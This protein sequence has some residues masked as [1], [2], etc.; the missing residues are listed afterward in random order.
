MFYHMVERVQSALDVTYAA[1][2]DPTRRAIL[3]RLRRGGAASVTQ[4]ARQFPVSLNAVSKHI[5]VLEGAGLVHRE[6]RGREHVL[7]LDAAP[8]AEAGSWIAEY[9]TF[10]HARADALAKHVEDRATQQSPARQGL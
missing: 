5:R 3:D 2:S 7:S 9:R 10:W 8:L 4:V 1:L 6:I